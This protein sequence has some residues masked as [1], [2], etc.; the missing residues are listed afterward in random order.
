M[1]DMS[2]ALPATSLQV[3]VLVGVEDEVP[4][5]WKFPWTSA[6]ADPEGSMANA[7]TSP[8]EHVK[9]TV[10]QS[11]EGVRMWSSPDGGG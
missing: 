10:R 5:V 11:R 8:A 1:G 4:V 7:E 2:L 9:T 3:L 6:K